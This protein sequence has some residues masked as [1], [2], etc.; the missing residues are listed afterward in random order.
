VEISENSENRL[1]GM[2][3]GWE[4]AGVDGFSGRDGKVAERTQGEWKAMK[5]G[6]RG[7]QSGVGSANYI[8]LRDMRETSSP[9][10]DKTSKSTPL[11]ARI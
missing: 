7:W 8:D 3:D 5:S 4:V 6:A 1:K 11:V 10:L 2:I 9:N